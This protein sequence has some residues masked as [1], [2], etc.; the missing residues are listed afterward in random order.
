MAISKWNRRNHEQARFQKCGQT[1]KHGHSGL[2]ESSVK[3]HFDHTLKVWDL[4]TAGRLPPS[5]A[6]R[7]QDAVPSPATKR[8]SRI[9]PAAGCIS[10]SYRNGPNT[11]YHPN[12]QRSSDRNCDTMGKWRFLAITALRIRKQL[13]GPETGFGEISSD[14]READFG[15][16]R[17]DSDYVWNSD[18]N[19][20]GSL[21]SENRALMFEGKQWSIRVPSDG[22]D[23]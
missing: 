18:R 7:Q 22:A 11:H 13:H 4:E 10:S 5:T 19:R 12:V 9:I 1:A 2:Q 17:R 15:T 6:T 20:L 8:S 23:M 21:P 16:V 3:L 14:V